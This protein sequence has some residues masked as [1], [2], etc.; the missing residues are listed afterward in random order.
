MRKLSSQILVFVFV[1]MN[2]MTSVHADCA[3][4][5]IDHSDK[6][7]SVLIL[8]ADA[9]KDTGHESSEDDCC[10]CLCHHCSAVLSEQKE[11]L[12]HSKPQLLSFADISF[13]SNIQYPLIRPPQA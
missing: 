11:S 10:S 13:P 9:D 1:L 8:D 6:I 2:V 12:S 4:A 3:D 7:A 5:S